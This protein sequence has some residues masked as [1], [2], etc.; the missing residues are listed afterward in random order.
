MKR[1]IVNNQY[2]FDTNL[3][4]RVGSTVVLPT[5]YWLR[6]V[7]GDTWE[8]KVT[9]LTSDYTGD[10]VQIISVKKSK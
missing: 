5:P 1:V 3:K 2:S 9:A 10:C 7:K 6:D 8:G 4:V